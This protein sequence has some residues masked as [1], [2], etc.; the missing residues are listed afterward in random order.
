MRRKAELLG[1]VRSGFLW[2]TITTDRNAGLP[3]LRR[4]DGSTQPVVS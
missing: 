1:E 2:S 4:E 3:D